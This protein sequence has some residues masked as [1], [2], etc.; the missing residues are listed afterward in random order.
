MPKWKV[1]TYS[2]LVVLFIYFIYFI[3]ANVYNVKTINNR[4][5]MG[6]DISFL[7]I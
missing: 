7:K 3:A 2:I 1:W 5:G 6:T 4:Y